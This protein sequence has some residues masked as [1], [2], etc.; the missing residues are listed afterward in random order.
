MLQLLQICSTE[1]L[2]VGTGLFGGAVHVVP[3]LEADQVPGKKRR[4]YMIHFLTIL[5]TNGQS[6]LVV[7]E[8][9]YACPVI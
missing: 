4:K 6:H 8:E 3:A 9:G 2:P 5:L 1:G 7:S